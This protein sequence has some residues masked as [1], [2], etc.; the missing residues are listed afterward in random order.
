MSCFP[1]SELASHHQKILVAKQESSSLELQAIPLSKF[2]FSS[3]TAHG[4][5]AF[6]S[7]ANSL[8][9]YVLINLTTSR[10]MFLQKT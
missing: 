3:C 5:P 6:S 10:N 9:I 2:S 7:S 8:N 1:A 4:L